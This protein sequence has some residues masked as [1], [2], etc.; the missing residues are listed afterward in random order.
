MCVANS[1]FITGVEE[2]S[3]TLYDI[4]PTSPLINLI[5]TKSNIKIN[6]LRYSHI[7]TYPRN[8]RELLN[9]RLNGENTVMCRIIEQTSTLVTEES[10]FIDTV[11]R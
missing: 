1:C 3:L 6:T 9:Q 2:H 11:I 5:K 10:T 4:I 7:Y 8:N